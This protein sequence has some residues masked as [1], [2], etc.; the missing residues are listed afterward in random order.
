MFLSNEATFDEFV[1]FVFDCLHNVRL[2][3][4]LLLLNRFSVRLNIE[5]MHGH[6]RVETRHIFI[7]PSKDVYIFLYKRYK[8]LLLYR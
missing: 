3:S 8:V 4:P 7:A 5:T 2:K 6:L 1:N